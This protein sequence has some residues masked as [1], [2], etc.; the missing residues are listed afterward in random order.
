V[1]TGHISDALGCTVT[2]VDLDLQ[3]G[4]LDAAHQAAQRALHLAGAVDG[5]PDGAADGVMVGEVV[6]G[7]ADMWVAL[8]GVAWERGHAEEAAEHLDRAADLAEAAGLPQQPYRWR[9][10]MSHLRESQGDVAA[11][12]ALLAEAERLFNSD[13][14]PNVRPV[15]AIRARLHIRTG[16][17]PAARR[18]AA[19]AGVSPAEDLTYL[20]EYEHTTLARLLMAEHATS[21]EASQLKQATKLLHQLHDTAADG[22]RTAAVVETSLLLAIASDAAGQ[23]QEALRL[24]QGAVNL[25]RPRRWLRPLLDAG[26][27]VLELLTLL[28]DEASFAEAVAAAASPSAHSADASRTAASTAANVTEPLV[29]PLSSRELDVLRLLGSDLDGPAIARHLNVSLPT[30]RTHTQHIYA[31][32]GVNSRRAAIRRAEE[33]GL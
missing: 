3:H 32:L 22:T 23:S 19:S 29:V 33:L 16:D 7:T 2:V 8:A 4:E 20:R 5:G 27:R 14:S 11:A 15:P 24:L 25:T 21:G 9:V 13:F 30:V 17:L 18:W 31:K 6:R 12:D 26:P 10:A 28:P 1:A